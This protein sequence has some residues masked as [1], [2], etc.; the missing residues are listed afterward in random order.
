MV[1]TKPTEEVVE[2]LIRERG[3]KLGLTSK[4]IRM[5]LRALGYECSPA[6]VTWLM[7]RLHQKGKVKKDSQRLWRLVTYGG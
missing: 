5:F 4:R 6:D 1:G 2:K 7:R 3:G